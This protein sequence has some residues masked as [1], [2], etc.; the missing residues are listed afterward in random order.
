LSGSD[1]TAAIGKLTFAP[2]VTSQ[3]I[4]VT[5]LANSAKKTAAAFN[6][7]LSVP[8]NATLRASQGTCTINNSVLT[9]LQPAAVNLVL[10]RR[11]V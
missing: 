5:I 8:S 7:A 4:S 3:T 11:L 2:G 10:A 9:I 6:M 1:Y